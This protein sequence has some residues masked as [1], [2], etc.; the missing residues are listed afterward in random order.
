MP[1][2][3][4]N[5]RRVDDEALRA[6]IN[7][8]RG[9]A[10]SIF[11]QMA[12]L[13]AIVLAVGIGFGILLLVNTSE[14]KPPT[15]AQQPQK[16]PTNSEPLNDAQREPQAT[17][18]AS[19]SAPPPPDFR[20]VKWGSRPALWMQKIGGPSGEDKIS[21]WKNSKKLSPF[22]NVPVAEEAY[23]FENYK[24]YAGEMFFDGEDNFNAL[25]T[26]LINALGT[27]ISSNDRLQTYKWQWRDPS[28]SLSLHYQ[29]KFSRATVHIENEAP[30]WKEIKPPAQSKA[31]SNDKS[32]KMPQGR[33]SSSK[34]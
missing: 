17:A 34:N 8:G 4:R 31:P 30:L 18:P 13:L 25:K 9:N 12:R 7:A 22:M 2:W 10:Q 29:S 28:F 26:A 11:K 21:T 5:Q 15:S 14:I 3:S 1:I 23:L 6:A 33:P 16:P 20:G 27:P 24:L 32:P 19:A